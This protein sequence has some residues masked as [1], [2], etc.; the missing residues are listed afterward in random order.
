MRETRTGAP[1]FVYLIT[2]G[3]HV[4]IGRAACPFPEMEVLTR[5]LG[6]LQCGNARLLTLVEH[7]WVAIAAATEGRLH[8]RFARHRIRGEWFRLTP[9]RHRRR[10]E[11]PDLRSGCPAHH[12]RGCPLHRRPDG[13]GPS[14]RS[15]KR[16][17]QA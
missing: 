6:I 13:F 11:D 14:S 17:R 5:R 8:K 15:P 1:G 7:A 3:A 2:D 12:P 10:H 4:K 16:R 9:G